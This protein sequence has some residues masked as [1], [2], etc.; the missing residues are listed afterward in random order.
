MARSTRAVS[1]HTQGE[2]GD[3]AYD[4]ERQGVAQDVEGGVSEGRPQ[5]GSP[6][7][8][9][10]EAAILDRAFQH[11]GDAAPEGLRLTRW[12]GGG[13]SRPS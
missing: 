12:M 2:G 7:E 8:Q 5:E 4:E 3:V 11:V 13:G 6:G 10:H 1:Y 9:D